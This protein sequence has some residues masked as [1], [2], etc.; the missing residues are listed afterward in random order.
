MNILMSRKLNSIAYKYFCNYSSKARLCQIVLKIKRTGYTAFMIEYEYIKTETLQDALNQLYTIVTMLRSEE[1]CP[2]D[3]KQTPKTVSSAILDETYEYIDGI[4]KNDPSSM[5]EELGDVLLNVFMSYRIQEEL[6]TFSPVDSINEVSEKLI[7]RHPHVFS[8]AEADDADSVLTLWDQ[9]KQDVEGKT[10]DSAD[11]F[12]KIPQQLPQLAH[13]YEVQKIMKK[14]G[15][16]WPEV[17]GVFDKIEEELE[18]VREAIQTGDEMDKDHVEE[19]IGDLLFSVVN[20][21]RYMK[22]DPQIA[23]RRTNNKVQNR[24]NQL[25]RRTTEKDIALHYDNLDQLNDIWEAI[26]EEE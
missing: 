5:K 8:D 11:L 13:A 6:E 3:R 16:D 22:V 10:L 23:L 25:Y 21:A 14:L 9:V 19:E 24:F 26:K 12:S 7:R 2:W 15:F 17:N 20:L 4:L 1:G 18:E